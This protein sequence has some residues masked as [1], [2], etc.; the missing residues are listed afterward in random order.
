MTEDSIN[1]LNDIYYHNEVNLESYLDKIQE[2]VEEEM[3]M[4]EYV[5]GDQQLQD[6]IK[7]TRQTLKYI[8]LDKNENGYASE[9]SLQHYELDI[10]KTRNNQNSGK[11]EK[12]SNPKN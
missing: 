11:R 2:N 7:E 1:A 8:S 3:E 6:T 4:S 12:G 5:S 9:R 10:N